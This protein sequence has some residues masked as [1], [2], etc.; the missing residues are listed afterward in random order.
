[1]ELAYCFTFD[2]AHRFGHYPEGHL[3]RGVHGHSFQAEIAV[4]GEPDDASGFVV[5]F[6]ALETACT[7]LRAELDHKFLNDI[8]DLKQPSLEHLCLW[9]WGRLA[10][11]FP[12]LAR[13]SV[14]RESCGQRCTYTGPAR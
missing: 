1:M 11:Q 4:Q 13:V 6:A 8:A 5:D 9:I 10:P 7:A 14:G 3:Y 2:A 12:Q